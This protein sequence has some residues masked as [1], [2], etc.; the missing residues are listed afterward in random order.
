LGFG[1]WQS[2]EV[3]PTLPQKWR[4]LVQLL[5]IITLAATFSRASFIA[6]VVLLGGLLVSKQLD[7]KS[8]IF[9]VA[10]L[11]ITLSILPKPGGE[12]VNLARTSTAQA[13]GLNIQEGLKLQG[14]QWWWGKGLFNVDRQKKY[15]TPDHAQ[16][17][18]SLPVM[19]VNAT[20]LVGL[21]LAGLVLHKWF[22]SWWLAD[23]V[24]TSLLIAV[25][26]HS[27][28]NNTFLQPF[29]FLALWGSKSNTTSKSS[30]NENLFNI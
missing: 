30:K 12:G 22:W 21:V 17:P 13:R 9:S 25:L 15:E 29:I 28:F 27:L 8:F 18:D 19:V 11:L 1:W 7:L 16:I 20:G 23:P 2:A 5:F 3:L 14:G 10:V 6:L 26:T 24:W 4:W